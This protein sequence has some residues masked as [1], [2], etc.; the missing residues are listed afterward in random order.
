L[1]DGD[2][3]QAIRT[4]QRS[5]EALSVL[6][7][8][9]IDEHTDERAD[10][11]AAMYDEMNGYIETLPAEQRHSLRSRSFQVAQL[12]Q[13]TPVMNFRDEPEPATQHPLQFQPTD[14]EQVVKGQFQS[15]TV[16]VTRR[17]RA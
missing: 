11:I 2:D 16:P 5:V 1:F 13:I 17:R 9:N 6:H 14:L 7:Y 3:A 10:R 4:L 15:V 12:Q 8:A